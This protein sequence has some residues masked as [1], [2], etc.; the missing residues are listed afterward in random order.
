L[1]GHP[2]FLQ[3]A[4]RL[5]DA[6]PI[7]PSK[8]RLPLVSPE[9][10]G[11][12]EIAAALEALIC[13][14]VTQGWRVRAFE[15]AFAKA[16]GSADAVFC[17]S[18]SSA[19]LLAMAG[20]GLKAGDDLMVPAVG[21][22]TTIWPMAQHGIIPVI[23][24]VD[25]ETL[26]VAYQRIDH[27]VGGVV[28]VYLLGNHNFR[29]LI[30]DPPGTITTTLGGACRDRA[31][32]D[33]CEALDSDIGGQKV[34]T[35]G[36]FGTFS[37]YISHHITTIEG[38]MVLCR[39]AEDASRLRSIRSHGLSR[40]L[41]P[42][43]RKQLEA[44]NPSIDP[45]FLF[46]EVGYNLR[47]DDVRAAIGLVQFAKREPWVH[48]RRS[49]ARIWTAALNQDHFQPIKWQP[50][51]VPFAFPLVCRGDF[52]AKLLTHLEAH[53]IENR[54]LVAGNMARQPA[55]QKIKHRIAGPLTGA[56]FLHDHACYVGIHPQMTPEQ[57][58]L[59]PE[60]LREFRP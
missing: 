14:P 44:A 37:F 45:R 40:D 53:G 56:N 3:A 21:W 10:L 30:D 35:F 28:L 22:P 12:E 4:Q 34:G 8:Y 27:P 43:M 11:V 23:A 2:D 58:D 32:E 47:G 24:D 31:F 17:N 26:C 20:L 52:K 25:P 5:R 7:Q 13:G 19:N 38:G 33:C 57:I 42:E 55:L 15:D 29:R 39:D 16:H 60:V 41:L 51:A 46:G 48:A 36:R 6:Y 49:I 9:A 1:I 54:P 50:G 59:L 18:G